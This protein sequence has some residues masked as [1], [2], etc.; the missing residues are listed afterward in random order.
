M[1]RES[2]KTILRQW[3]IIRFLLDS[4]YVSTS[5]IRE[6]LLT[7]SIDT[8]LRTI[9]RDLNLLEKVMPI[10]CRRDS[11][12]HSWR[13]KKV[14]E[15]H[16]GYLNLT[17]ALTLRLVEEQLKDVMSAKLMAELQP[18][19]IRARLVT[20]MTSEMEQLESVARSTSTKAP[21]PDRGRG[22]YGITGAPSPVAT[23]LY[24][25]R[26]LVGSALA[27]V[28]FSPSEKQPNNIQVLDVAIGELIEVMRQEGLDELVENL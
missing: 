19:F 6:H 14:Q 24:G 4:H 16:T 5:S 20:G 10:E 15:T 22:G 2:S 23:I 18:L 25:I 12:P 17:Q 11:M 13:W 7:V 27:L 1:S 8:E 28:T 9:Q 26:S 3:H 21:I